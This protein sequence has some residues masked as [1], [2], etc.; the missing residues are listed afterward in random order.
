[1]YPNF[2]NKRDRASKREALLEKLALE[3]RLEAMKREAYANAIWA[4]DS[5]QTKVKT[6][7]EDADTLARMLTLMKAQSGTSDKPNPNGFTSVGDA[8]DAMG[9]FYVENA[10]GPANRPDAGV[11]S[12]VDN[13]T[14]V[15]ME[16]PAKKDKVAPD[17]SKKYHDDL[18]KVFKAYPVLSNYTF[19]PG[20]VID[21]DGTT[22]ERI[23]NKIESVERAQIKL[24]NVSDDVARK[25]LFKRWKAY[26]KASNP[27]GT[28]YREDLN[29]LDDQ[30]MEDMSV[31]QRLDF[32]KWLEEEM[33]PAVPSNKRE[34][35]DLTVSLD[36]RV[37]KKSPETA[38][39]VFT[40]K[41]PPVD[42]DGN[43]LDPK[44][45]GIEP[46]GAMGYTGYYYSLLDGYVYLNLL[47]LDADKFLPILQRGRD[48]I[49]YFIELLFGTH[50]GGHPEWMGSRLKSII[51][52]DGSYRLKPM[53]ADV[54]QT[55]RDHC[56]LLF[57]C[58]YSI[59]GE[60]RA[61]DPELV[62]FTITPY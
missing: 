59:S 54:L 31:A 10:Q 9:D 36:T 61:L 60:N 3:Q 58:L 13:A 37:E 14:D 26:T 5:E 41:R 1:M 8:Y 4:T 32:D 62:R 42:E 46:Y 17:D 52:D 22:F 7:T 44:M 47:L 18:V 56:A 57:R 15:P 38:Q 51:R 40:D 27:P 35:E 23:N 48:G 20:F 24:S 43:S 49:P 34:L 19:R 11:F 21:D 12:S 53:T 6:A 29:R 28:I 55:I 2:D 45:W 50:D 39:V 30:D 33:N 25:E 16:E